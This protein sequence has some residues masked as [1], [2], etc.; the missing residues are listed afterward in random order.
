D[1]GATRDFVLERGNEIRGVVVDENEGPLQGASIALAPLSPGG[2]AV[3]AFTA[4]DGTFTIAGEASGLRR[5]LVQGRGYAPRELRVPGAG[6]QPVTIRMERSGTLRGTIVDR[7]G[8]PAPGAK[9]G[10]LSRSAE[11]ERYD[12]AA[13]ADGAGKFEVIGLPRGGAVLEL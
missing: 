3:R 12:T 4:A 9:L 6:G 11:A 10:F 2:T 5:L 1:E 8:R 13:L 7:H